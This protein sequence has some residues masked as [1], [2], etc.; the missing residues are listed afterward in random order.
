MEQ[1]IDLFE[2]CTVLPKLPMLER[3]Q[4]GITY[5]YPDLRVLNQNAVQVIF[6]IL[7]TVIAEQAINIRFGIPEKM[8]EQ[9]IEI[10]TDI[11]MAF[12]WKAEKKGKNGFYAGGCLVPTVERNNNSITFKVPDEISKTIYRTAHNKEHVTIFEIVKALAEN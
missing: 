6:T 5:R 2:H 9:E 12:T 1:L 8:D 11:V 3:K 10:I 7:N 4:D